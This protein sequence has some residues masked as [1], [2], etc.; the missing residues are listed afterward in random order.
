MIRESS[1]HNGNVFGRYFWRS[2]SGCRVCCR[3]NYVKWQSGTNVLMPISYLR[4]QI[5]IWNA[6]LLFVRYSNSSNISQNNMTFTSTAYSETSWY[7]VECN[8]TTSVFSWLWLKPRFF[9]KLEIVIHPL[10]FILYKDNLFVYI[11]TEHR[12]HLRQLEIVFLKCP[13]QI[14]FYCTNSHLINRLY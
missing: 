14:M 13:L 2:L 5:L 10:K 1:F 6:T 9:T 12:F 8:Y 4:Y 7:I 11:E 3:P